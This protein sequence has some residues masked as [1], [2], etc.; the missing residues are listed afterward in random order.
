MGSLLS[1]CLEGPMGLQVTP[2]CL[3]VS[4]VFQN[5]I[6]GSRRSDPPANGFLGPFLGL[7]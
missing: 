7:M 2:I 6:L 3:L 1:S 5:L 4:I